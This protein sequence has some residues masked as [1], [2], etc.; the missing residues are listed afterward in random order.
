MYILRERRDVVGARRLLSSCLERTKLPCYNQPRGGD[1]LCVVNRYLSNL[2]LGYV[3][4]HIY[5]YFASTCVVTCCYYISR[6]YYSCLECPLMAECCWLLAIRSWLSD[7]K[8]PLWDRR[9]CRGVTISK[10]QM[11]NTVQ[12]SLITKTI[13]IQR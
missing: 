13:F 3:S 8:N 11:F 1:V 6:S 2:S 10:H 4:Q 5:R 7:T 12:I 9:F